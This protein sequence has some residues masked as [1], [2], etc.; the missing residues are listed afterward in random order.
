MILEKQYIM[1]VGSRLDGFISH[2]LC[3]TKVVMLDVRPLKVQIPNL[4]FQECDCTDMKSI[5]SDSIESLSSLHA[6]E[7]F[8]LG[9]YGDPVDPAGYIKAIN[10]IKRVIKKNGN[11]LFSVPIG[12][13]RLEFNSYRVF[14]PFYVIKLFEGFELKEFSSVNDQNKLIINANPKDYENAFYSCGLF[15]FIKR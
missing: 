5:K 9:R 8:G 4:E 15:H 13:Q 6:V 11:I 1:I 12:K 3:F 2:C 7:H 10:E 14:D